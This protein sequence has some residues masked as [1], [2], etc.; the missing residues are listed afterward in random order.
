VPAE[1]NYLH[2]WIQKFTALFKGNSEQQ[3]FHFI[4]TDTANSAVQAV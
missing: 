4:D 1:E 3:R 2:K